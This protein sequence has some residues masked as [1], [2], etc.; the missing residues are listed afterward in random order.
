MAS[1][2]GEFHPSRRGSRPEAGSK[3]RPILV[4]RPGARRRRGESGQISLRGRRRR[5]PASVFP[6]ERPG[7]SGRF[8]SRLDL[9]RGAKSLNA[10]PSND[11]RPRCGD[12]WAWRSAARRGEL[13]RGCQPQTHGG[14]K[15]AA[16]RP[17]FFRPGISRQ[18]RLREISA[19]TLRNPQV[20]HRP[21]A[22]SISTSVRRAREASSP[23]ENIG[24][25]EPHEPRSGLAAHNEKNESAGAE[26]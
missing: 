8:G 17:K 22:T 19:L 26:A 2:L 20:D 10:R 11:F 21:I 24:A 16:R 15:P 3:K 14:R 23:P 4:G 5:R 9:A 18:S 12:A 13:R 25:H 7:L 1:L 6:T